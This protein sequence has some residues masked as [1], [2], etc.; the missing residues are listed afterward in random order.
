MD[1]FL[2]TSSTIGAYLA[3]SHFAGTLDKIVPSKIPVIAFYGDLSFIY[4]F[5]Q[6]FGYK[7]LDNWNGEYGRENYISFDEERPKF[8]EKAAK[9]FR[10]TCSS[11]V[12]DMI[13]VLSYSPNEIPLLNLTLG[14]NI[15][16]NRKNQIVFRINTFNGI[17]RASPT[18]LMSWLLKRHIKAIEQKLGEKPDEIAFYIF[19]EFDTPAKFRIQNGLK[20]SCDLAEIEC[21]FV[22]TLQMESIQM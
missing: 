22:E 3:L 4:I 15:T 16:K 2:N 7:L 8:F 19:D 5:D 18:L 9:I 14:Y 10:S 11:V 1:N 21:S 20:E 17:K 12:H 13:K 6:V